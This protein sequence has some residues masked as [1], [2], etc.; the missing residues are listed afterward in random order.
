MGQS[1]K[2]LDRADS[3]LDISFYYPLLE[4]FI[5]WL[6]WECYLLCPNW[7]CRWAYETSGTRFLQLEAKKDFLL[8]LESFGWKNMVRTVEGL[9]PYIWKEASF[10]LERMMSTRAKTNKNQSEE[11]GKTQEQIHALCEHV[12]V[13][14]HVW[15]VVTTWTVAHHVLCLWIL[16]ARTLE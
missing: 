6:R 10:W 11:M 7:A 3:C 1:T 4:E 12:C 15:S 16:Q 5:I 14:S 13:L 9:L 2:A 8:C